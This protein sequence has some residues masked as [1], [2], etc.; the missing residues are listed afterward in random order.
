[1]QTFLP[2]A[3]LRVS[4]QVLDSARLGKQRVETFQILRA[5]TWPSY[6]WKNHP[7]VRMWRGFV[8]GLVLYGVENCREWTRRGNADTVLPQLLVWT[9]GEVPEDPALPPWFGLEELHLSHRARLVQKDPDAYRPLFGDL[10]DVPYLW[11]ADVFPRWPVRRGPRD[12]DLDDALA[13]LGLP[14]ARAG[15]AEAAAAVADGRDCLLVAAPGH[16]GSTGALLA[17]L[18]TPGRTLLVGPSVH[19]DPEPVPDVVL[20]APRVLPPPPA[21]DDPASWPETAAEVDAEPARVP[22]L[23]RPPSHADLAAMQAEQDPP[24]WVFVRPDR[25]PDL[26]GFGLVVLD[27]ADRLPDLHLD[28]GADRPPVLAVVPQAGPQERE[29]LAARLGLR[30]PVH[31]GGGWDPADTWLGVARVPSAPARRRL[32][33]ALAAQAGP[34][35]VQVAGRDRADRLAGALVGAGLRAASWGEG[36]RASR[37][38]AAVGAWRSRRLAALVVPHGLLPPLGRARVPLLVDADPP[39]GPEQW[40][41][42]VA[43]V[44]PTAAVLVVG[45]DAPAPVA[46]YA[47]APG[48]RR[49]ALLD[50][51]GEPV[52]V[53]CGR[54]D[55]CAP[56]AGPSLSPPARGAAAVSA[57]A[58]RGRGPRRGCASPAG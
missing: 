28:L 36:M 55:V 11:P 45:P 26:T 5:L 49:A 35:L 27:G 8:P 42:E 51:L 37:A 3:D 54:C 23:A 44:S 4:C 21:Q 34:A 6:A 29:H 10:P 40:R 20:V 25:L 7:A 19:P 17:G 22:V 43:E 16:G 47:D 2:Y 32:L 24:E 18:V 12:L 38:A 31:G 53:P 48:C 9:A 15:Q 14:A 13:L 57:G 56:D 50:P 58:G 39:E 33:P 30:D 52:Q 41:D 1:M 46:A